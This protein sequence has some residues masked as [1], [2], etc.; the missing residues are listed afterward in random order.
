MIKQ[1]KITLL[2][3]LLFVFLLAVSIAIGCGSELNIVD[4]GNEEITCVLGSRLELP[5][6][7]AKDKKGKEYPVEISV[8]R[9]SDNARITVIEKSFD[10]IFI[11]GYNIIYKAFD[12]GKEAV[13]TVVVKVEDV[14]EPAI[15]CSSNKYAEVGVKYSWDNI[16]VYD[17]SGEVSYNVEVFDKST[18]ERVI[19]END[20]FIPTK[21]G[22]YELLISAL[23]A[24]GNKSS[25]S[26][27]I[28]S[29]TTKKAG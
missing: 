5:E 19:S 26:Y 16:F 9:K 17:A 22:E 6:Y 23:D 4:W 11:D 12:V 25:L 24:S 27:V 29:R 28:F 14:C 18:G 2:F 7:I 21:L 8:Y 20:G 3:F 13:K 15:Y 1:V 10:I